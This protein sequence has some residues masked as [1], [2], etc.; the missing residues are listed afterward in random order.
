MF[1]DCVT[2]KL[3]TNVTE[4]GGF[5][6][7]KDFMKMANGKVDQAFAKIKRKA[8]KA[9]PVFA[10]ALP[11]G[12][13]I[14]T[15][16]YAYNQHLDS[17]RY[18]MEA[19]GHAGEIQAY[20]TFA[21]HIFDYQRAIATQNPKEIER[22]EQVIQTLTGDANLV[23][24]VIGKEG[25]NDLMN[26]YHNMNTETVS[27]TLQMLGLKDAYELEEKMIQDPVFAESAKNLFC[28]NLYDAVAEEEF[29]MGME[30]THLGDMSMEYNEALQNMA[31]ASDQATFGTGV[32]VALTAATMAVS[33]V[34][35]HKTK[36]K[37]KKLDAEVK[38]E[39]EEDLSR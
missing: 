6:K 25:Y 29:K 38:A 20:T 36:Q 16:L 28:D 18:G 21:N 33:M 39:K 14:A 31:E 4:N 13:A 26:M 35:V 8:L 12:A 11:G 19:L 9:A 2:I 30:G 10:A 37:A 32:G 23:E 7:V 1:F 3:V 17:L 5:M 34:L 15:Y 24:R 22:A 27:E